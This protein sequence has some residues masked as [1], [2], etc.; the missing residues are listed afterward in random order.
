MPT[1]DSQPERISMQM[2]PSIGKGV[3]KMSQIDTA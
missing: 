2:M 1:W 3:L